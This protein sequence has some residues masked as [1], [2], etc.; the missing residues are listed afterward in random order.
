MR[1]RNQIYLT[2]IN[3][4]MKQVIFI[5]HHAVGTQSLVCLPGHGEMVALWKT[6]EA[7]DLQ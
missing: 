2:I 4:L 3:N 6:S 5:S 1:Q 7:L